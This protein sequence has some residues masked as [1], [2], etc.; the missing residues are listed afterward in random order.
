VPDA[1]SNTSPLLYLYRIQAIDFLPE[2][3]GETWAPTAVVH[4][5]KAGSEKGLDVPDPAAYEWLRVVN[6]M[7]IPS[8]W[9]ATDLG[10]GELAA[11]SL[12]IEHRDRIVLLDD[13]LA[14]RI[15]ESAGLT[16]WGTLRV[17]LEAKSRGLLNSVSP[18]VDRLQLS[19]MRISSSVRQR[20]LTLAGESDS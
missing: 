3:F 20:I 4:E 7:A 16:V 11:L 19:G 18:S 5:L 10:P 6:P 2:L 17:L 8:E 1:I 12:A 15:A 9:L 13:A 14:R